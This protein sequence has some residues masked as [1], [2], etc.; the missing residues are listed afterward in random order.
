MSVNAAQA[1]AFY[2]EAS[3]GGEVWAIRDDSGYPAP[4]TPEGRAMPFWS[5]R[6]R[7]EKVLHGFPHMRPSRPLSFR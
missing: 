6:S 1:A 3:D 7:A 5:K 2:R 4:E